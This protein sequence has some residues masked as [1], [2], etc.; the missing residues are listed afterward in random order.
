MN[1]LNE[2]LS[3]LLFKD[4]SAILQISGTSMYPLLSNGQHITVRPVSP[5]D[6]Q[7]GKCCVYIAN[8]NLILHRIIWIFRNYVY[9]AGD[10]NCNI[11]KINKSN[12]IAVPADRL[13]HRVTISIILINIL[14]V[15][16][17]GSNFFCRL[18][19]YII[20]RIIKRS[21]IHEKKL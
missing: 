14:F 15:L 2:F 7:P 6:L 9:I 11:E 13:Y 18:K 16:L 12:I 5:T 3:T 10:A 21:N 17:H 8:G 19:R 4:E 1:H 20:K